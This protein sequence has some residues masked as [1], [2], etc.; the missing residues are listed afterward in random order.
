MLTSSSTWRAPWVTMRNMM[1]SLSFSDNAPNPLVPTSTDIVWMMLII[2]I[3]VVSAVTV[4]I[5]EYRRRGWV[6][7]TAWAGLALLLPVF[8]VIIWLL[9]MIVQ[10]RTDDS[11]PHTRTAPEHTRTA[12]EHTRTTPNTLPNT[13]ER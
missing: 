7:A 2:V 6:L 1:A 3:P 9:A 13:I 12:P 11:R 8:G 5:I 10:S 4:F